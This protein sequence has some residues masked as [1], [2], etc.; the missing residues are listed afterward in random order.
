M[1]DQ[2]ARAVAVFMAVEDFFSPEFQSGYVKGL[3]YTLREGNKKL[4]DCLTKWLEEGKVV[5]VDTAKPA[6]AGEAKVSGQGEVQTITAAD[7]GSIDALE[8]TGTVG[9]KKK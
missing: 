8:L 5:L 7:V 1:V 2:R 3:T 9:G 4:G 6:V